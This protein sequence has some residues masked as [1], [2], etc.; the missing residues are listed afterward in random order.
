MT[1]IRNH[2]SRGFGA[3]GGLYTQHDARRA[4]PFYFFNRGFGFLT[5]EGFADLVAAFFVATFDLAEPFGL[6][7]TAALAL[8][9]ARALD[10]FTLAAVES[11]ASI[12]ASV[13]GRTSDSTRLLRQ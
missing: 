12:S 3:F 8:F 9:V 6:E 5:P 7:A 1:Q 4:T 2:A 11:E 10:A 13:V